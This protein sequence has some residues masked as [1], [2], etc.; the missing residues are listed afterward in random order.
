[1]IKLIKDL[2]F[3]HGLLDTGYSISSVTNKEEEIMY[4]VRLGYRHNYQIMRGITT[5][6]LFSVRFSKYCSECLTV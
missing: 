1:M 3:S 6:I 5:L 2:G 4:L